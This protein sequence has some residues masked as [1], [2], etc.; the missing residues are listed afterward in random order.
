[1]QMSISGAD[2]KDNF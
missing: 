1:M 2:F